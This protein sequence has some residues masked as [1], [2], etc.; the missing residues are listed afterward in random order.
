M[1]D[2]TQLL[3]KMRSY[4]ALEAVRYDNGYRSYVWSYDELVSRIDTF[5]QRLVTQ[6]RLHPGEHALPVV[7]ADDR[8]LGMLSIS[9]LCPARLDPPGDR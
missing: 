6:Y 9:A 7:D 4:G 3:D 5:R 1:K 8:F 2:L